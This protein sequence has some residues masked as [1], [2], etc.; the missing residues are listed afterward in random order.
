VFYSTGVD[1]SEEQQRDHTLDDVEDV[2]IEIANHFD[3]NDFAVVGNGF[4]T[5][6]S[7]N[8]VA[9]YP[10]RVTSMVISNIY[11]FIDSLVQLARLGVSLDF[12]FLVDR[13]GKWTP[14]SLRDQFYCQKN[15]LASSTRTSRRWIR[16]TS[17]FEVTKLEF[18]CEH[19]DRIL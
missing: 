14:Y 13:F 1:I 17:S 3:I 6:I 5:Y 15:L 19:S 4:R 16:V 7:I 10:N 9:R 12:D 2:A 11:Q 18:A 8:A